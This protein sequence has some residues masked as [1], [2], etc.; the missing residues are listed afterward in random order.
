MATLGLQKEKPQLGAGALGAER[1]H[2]TRATCHPDF[3]RFP[4]LSGLFRRSASR[5][6]SAR[7]DID[8]LGSLYSFS[9][10]FD[11]EV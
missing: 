7:L 8:C 4:G 10:L 6:W 1:N 11:C 5:G 2:Y 9:G 3:R